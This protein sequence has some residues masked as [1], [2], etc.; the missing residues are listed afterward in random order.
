M[1]GNI[2]LSGILI[3]STSKAI[4]GA[5]VVLKS[6]KTGDVISGIA[7]SFVTGADGS[8]SVTVPYGTYK[9]YIEIEGEQTAMPGFFNVYDYSANGSLQDFLYQPCEENN[10]PMFLFE[11]EVIRKDVKGMYDSVKSDTEF[12]TES[13]ATIPTKDDFKQVQDRV[14]N[15]T[16]DPAN[17]ID[18]IT[19]QAKDFDA[20][21][22]SPVYSMV[23]S[24][25]GGWKLSH[26]AKN[27]ISKFIDLPSYWKSILFDVVY[28]NDFAN[29]GAISVSCGV[30]FSGYGES[31]NL[32][33]TEKSS[34]SNVNGTPLILSKIS[35]TEAIPV[36]VGKFCAIRISRN[37]DSASDTLQTSI[38]VIAVIIRR[39]S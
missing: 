7:G 6:V 27:A 39:G 22:G 20:V 5:K 3:D 32:P 9:V 2:T 16:I 18:S 12:V 34:V 17:S 14:N 8:Y 28:C 29:D 1:I 25:I 33:P 35:T 38:S 11:L 30:G 31:I 24:R 15:L 37:G 19:I 36:S 10:I 13:V 21:I 26:G 23:S 4:T